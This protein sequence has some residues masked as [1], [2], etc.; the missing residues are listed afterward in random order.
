MN[1]YQP[2]CNEDFKKP[3][4]TGSNVCTTKESSV[5]FLLSEIKFKNME[6]KN[7]HIKIDDLIDMNKSLQDKLLKAYEFIV[8]M[9]DK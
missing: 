8:K 2:K 5:D 9:T 6:I 1:G 4:T 3:P 7:L